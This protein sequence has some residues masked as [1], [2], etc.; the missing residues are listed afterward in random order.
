MKKNKNNMIPF[1]I[2]IIN[3]VIVVIHFKNTYELP[4]WI[5][6]ILDTYGTYSFIPAIIS[7]VLT[8]MQEKSSYSSFNYFLNGCYLII[9]ASMFLFFLYASMGI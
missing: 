9:Y 3:V 2:G 7:I 8:K 5:D 6:K 4:Y 1:L